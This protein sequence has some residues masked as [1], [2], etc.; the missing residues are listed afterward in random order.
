M[1]NTLKIRPEYA[2]KMLVLLFFGII[3]LGSKAQIGAFRNIVEDGIV[4]F[5][6]NCFHKDSKGY[7][8]TGGTF[9]VQRFDGKFVKP[10]KVP[11]NINK[12]NAIAE[13]P[14]G[15]LYFATSQGLLLLHPNSDHLQAFLPEK[16]SDNCLTINATHDHT[17]YVGTPSGLTI[18]KDNTI[19]SL[20]ISTPAFPYDKV[21][22]IKGSDTLLWLLTPGGLV[23]WNSEKEQGTTYPFFNTQSQTLCTSMC[24]NDSM[25]YIGTNGKGIYTFNL[26]NRRLKPFIS[27]GNGNISSLDTGK[28]NA[29]F[30][31]TVGTGVFEVSTKNAKVIRAF[32]AN[33]NSTVKLSSNMISSLMVDDFNILWVG[34]EEHLGFDYMFLDPKP[35]EIYSTQKFTSKNTPINQFYLG[36]DF[37]L[38]AGLYGLYLIADNKDNVIY[39]EAGIGKA[40]QLKPGRIR[41]MVQINEQIILAG[42][43]GIYSFDLN[44]Y[45]IEVYKPFEFI[46]DISVYYMVM[47]KNRRLWVATEAGL[48]L[49]DTQT[50]KMQIF[51]TD[52]TDIPDENIRF[53]YFDSKER[54]W[55]CTT[56]GICFWDENK[57]QFYHKTFPDGFIDKAEIHHIL[58]DRKGN[59]IFCYNER[60]VL[61]S[62]PD[63][64]ECRAVCTE[65]DAGFTGLRI[66]KTLQKNDGTFWFIGSRGTIKADEALKNFEMYSIS[67]G[68]YEPYATDGHFDDKN[69]LWLS[70][71][72]GLYYA[73]GNDDR[74]KANMAITDLT[75]NGTSRINEFKQQISRG[76][77]FELSQKDNNIAFHFALLDY[78]RPDLMVYECR[79]SGVDEWWNILR[80]LNTFHYKDLKPGD[81]TFTVRHNM[82]DATKRE[83]HFTIKK[84]PHISRWFIIPVILALLAIM[85]MG[86]FRKGPGRKKQPDK[87]TPPPSNTPEK[88]QKYRFNKLNDADAAT[89]MARLD[90][91]MNAKHLYRNDQLKI[92]D[93]SKE[94]NCSNQALSQV[95]NVHMNCSYYDYVNRYRLEA[96]KQIVKQNEHNK[97]TLKAMAKACGFSSYT[98]F[99]RAFKEHEGLTPNAFIQA[100]KRK[101]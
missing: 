75:I 87:A 18:I 6:V 98:S 47:D 79:L 59:F 33:P 58:E 38:L 66:L 34:S 67:E 29:L 36:D 55:I 30:A 43:S 44:T 76:K 27:I 32:N 71:N 63:F 60:N 92:S 90:A 24:R 53:V 80:G 25:F 49:V 89:L 69:V 40:K 15:D 21:I 57:G 94:I 4:D 46:K 101:A 2:G 11:E 72:E 84:S 70:N 93:L 39:F 13:T 61:F 12:I 74:L 10:Y 41:S 83:V 52:N 99:Y 22:D 65:D 23:S 5:Q 73:S 20:S 9:M 82:D 26:H 42:E 81:Y 85:A 8:W 77:T 96:F 28:N 78:T 19:K 37:K 14:D 86:W 31:G 97:F 48:Y 35:F 54:T 64:T 45:R 88:D 95:F 51:N 1:H 16:I 100:N 7:I 56:K 91:C 3:S 68:L 17:I 50:L 62:N